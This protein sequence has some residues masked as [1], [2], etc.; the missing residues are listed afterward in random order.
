MEYSVKF[1]EL[2]RLIINDKK[3]EIVKRLRPSSEFP[4]NHAFEPLSHFLNIIRYLF[5]EKKDESLFLLLQEYAKKDGLLL[6]DPASEEAAMLYFFMTSIELELKFL[7]LLKRNAKWEI[8]KKIELQILYDWFTRL[9]VKYSSYFQDSYDHCQILYYLGKLVHYELKFRQG[10]GLNENEQSRKTSF[11]AGNRQAEIQKLYVEETQKKYELAKAKGEI[12]TLLYDEQKLY[13]KSEES[14]EKQK[15]EAS[16]QMIEPFSVQKYFLKQLQ[17]AIEKNFLD[18]YIDC[19]KKRRDKILVYNA[20]YFN[21][22]MS[23]FCFIRCKDTLHK[24]MDW[25]SFKLPVKQVLDHLMDPDAILDYE[26]RYGVAGMKPV[27]INPRLYYY[28]FEPEAPDQEAPD[29]GMSILVIT[30]KE[31]QEFF[32][33]PQVISA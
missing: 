25:K 8:L 10:L 31:L 13:K 11:T 15:I 16:R 14:Y 26:M 21:I 32:G 18:G 3:H 24:L 2:N 30:A 33:L 1:D 29:I 17:E 12:G 20:Y 28:L 7:I 23:C 4:S 19:E 22:L 27:R 5:K 6:T 9:H